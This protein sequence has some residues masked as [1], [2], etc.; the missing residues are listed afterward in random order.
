MRCSERNV[1]DSALLL[2]VSSWIAKSMTSR[3][4]TSETLFPRHYQMCTAI[5]SGLLS[6][7]CQLY[8]VP[9]TGSFYH[10]IVWRNDVIESSRFCQLTSKF[11]SQVPR[12]L[13]HFRLSTKSKSS[14]THS[15][16]YF[17]FLVK[18]CGKYFNEL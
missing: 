7:Y 12:H 4:P 17:W 5:D 6:S 8:F 9:L 3:S 1:K 15:H 11:L 2:W 14:L 13:R 10:V 16:S 18:A